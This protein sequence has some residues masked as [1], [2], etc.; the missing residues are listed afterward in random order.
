MDSPV[1]I[2]YTLYGNCTIDSAVLLAPVSTQRD[3]TLSRVLKWHTEDTI[4]FIVDRVQYNQLGSSSKFKHKFK[5]KE[6]QERLAN[7]T[8]RWT[9]L[10]DNFLKNNYKYLSDNTVALALSI[11]ANRVQNRRSFLGLRKDA[12]PKEDTLVIVWDNRNK[13]EVDLETEGLTLLKDC[14]R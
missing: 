2:Q 13:F 7:R 4:P 5:E 14:L 11:P 12:Q 8:H 1:D 3:L 9:E 6:L 10:E